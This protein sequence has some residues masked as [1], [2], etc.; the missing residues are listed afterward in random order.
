MKRFLVAALVA[1]SM[2]G[3]A[4]CSGAWT[5]IAKE[6]DVDGGIHG[7]CRGAYTPDSDIVAVCFGAELTCWLQGVDPASGFY[8]WIPLAPTDELCIGVQDEIRKWNEL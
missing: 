2:L 4:G 5:V 8:L 1:F 7:R 6:I 3:L